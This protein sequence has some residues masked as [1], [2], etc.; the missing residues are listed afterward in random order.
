M[1]YPSNKKNI[2]T[3]ELQHFAFNI[4]DFS[5]LALDMPVGSGL[6]H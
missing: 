2:Q 5:G 1:F 3:I 6:R 4:S